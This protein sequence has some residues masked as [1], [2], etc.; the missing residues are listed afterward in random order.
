MFIRPLLIELFASWVLFHV[1]R[2]LCV[3]GSMCP[4]SDMYLN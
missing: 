1:S 3:P 2:V 4:G